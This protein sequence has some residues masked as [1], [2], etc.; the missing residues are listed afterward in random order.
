MY[1]LEVKS[2]P[3]SETFFICNTAAR[4]FNRLLEELA[5]IFFISTEIK[6]ELSAGMAF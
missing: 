4:R 1:I 3:Q 2:I 6:A 5:A